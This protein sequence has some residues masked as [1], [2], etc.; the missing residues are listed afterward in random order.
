MRCKGFTLIELLVVIAIIAILAAILFPVFAKA[1]DKA[2]EAS[3]QSNLKNL[4]M[5]IMMY[6][7]DY[8]DTWPVRLHNGTHPMTPDDT[9]HSWAVMVYPYVK[10]AK[11]F[12]CPAGGAKSFPDSPGTL[13]DGSPPSRFAMGYAI[14]GI[15]FWAVGPSDKHWTKSDISR[16]ADTLLAAD[17]NGYFMGVGN[18]PSYWL[19]VVRH[20]SHTAASCAFCDGHVK[21]VKGDR[22]YRGTSRPF[23]PAEQGPF[24][25]NTHTIWGQYQLLAPWKGW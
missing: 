3:C 7:S 1:R 13:W 16:P 15:L 19:P 20:T 6:A 9:L 22:L 12:C 8:D 25:W 4:S 2:L 11:V 18:V 21:A 17:S 10:N 5:A 14:N 23:A 24:A